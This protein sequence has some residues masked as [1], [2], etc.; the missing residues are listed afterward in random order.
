MAVRNKRL[1]A[2]LQHYFK[3]VRVLREGEPFRYR[4]IKRDGKK[5]IERLDGGEEYCLCCPICKETRF[6]LC[7]N[8]VF[9]EFLEG[10]EMRH[11]IHCWNEEC[12]VAGKLLTLYEEF[13]EIAPA[14][15]RPMDAERVDGPISIEAMVADCQKNLMQVAGVT[16]VDEL[17]VDHPAARYLLSRR[18]DP[19]ALG[20]SHAIGFCY[21]EAY[22][23]RH[24]HNRIIIPILYQGA[25][26]GWQA[27][28]IPGLT[29]LT[30]EPKKADKPWP[31]REP[32]YW[33]SPGTR[34]SF[35]L[36]SYDIAATQDTVV[37]SEGPTDA[38]RVG[39]CGVAA[40]GRRISLYQRKLLLETWAERPGKIVLIGDPG[41]EDDWRMNK[42]L[43]DD[44]VGDPGKVKLILPREKDPGEMT[45]EELWG[46]IHGSS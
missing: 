30:I 31:Y 42:E 21:N 28:A 34:K 39:P 6:R 10:V 2:F 8:H 5:F 4:V 11:V 18:Y 32:K 37:V 17:P 25:Y 22:K 33:T 46:M 26:I 19:Q 9:G 13:C 23:V 44:E 41:F 43:L 16:R 14:D 12:E 1:Y 24:A 3:R 40:L 45:R 35:F 38:W 15:L 36:Y 29:K 20:P 7:V 27:R